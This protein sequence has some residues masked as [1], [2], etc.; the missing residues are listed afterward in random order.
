MTPIL[1]NNLELARSEETYTG[2]VAL[3]LCGRLA[4]MIDQSNRDQ[5]VIEYSLIGSSSKFHLPSMQL[6]IN[7]TL[8]FVCQRCLEGVQLDF[9]LLFD[10]VISEGEPEGFSEDEDVDWVEASREMNITTLVEDELLV[11][12]PLAPTHQHVCKQMKMESGEKHNPFAS[13]K[14]LIK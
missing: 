10:Y 8:P 4:E 6:K 2:R 13:L 3:D 5:W 14:G 1:I 11:A 12:T 9:E 7:A